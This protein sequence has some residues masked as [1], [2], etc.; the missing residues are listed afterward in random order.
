MGIA[1][2]NDDNSE[3]SRQLERG[4]IP[5]TPGGWRATMA[6][7]VRRVQTDKAHPVVARRRS[8]PCRRNHKKLCVRWRGDRVIGHGEAIVRGIWQRRCSIVIAICTLHDHGAWSPEHPRNEQWDLDGCLPRWT[9][10]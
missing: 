2:W 9:D 6:P 1:R 7:L 4:R 10:T 3:F 8:A 5:S